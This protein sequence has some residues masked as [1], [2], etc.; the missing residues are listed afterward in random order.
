MNILGF[1]MPTQSLVILM[2]LVVVFIACVLLAFRTSRTSEN[3][4]KV[5]KVLDILVGVKIS[6]KSWP[7]VKKALIEHGVIQPEGHR[8]SKYGCS[9]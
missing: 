1:V 6:G 2:G 8:Q 9:G 5:E 3:V 4:E 7:V